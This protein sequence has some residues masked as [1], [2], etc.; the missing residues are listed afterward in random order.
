MNCP[1]DDLVRSPV[2][3]RMSGLRQSISFVSPC[4][5]LKRWRLLRSVLQGVQAAQVPHL[6]TRHVEKQGTA[7]LVAA[8]QHWAAE[9]RQRTGAPTCVPI[10]GGTCCQEG[11]GVGRHAFLTLRLSL[12]WPLA[13]ALVSPWQSSGCTLC[14]RL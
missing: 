14:L 7:A 10:E 6:L 1:S 11:C 13:A 3:H 5:V 2:Q 8:A 9:C 4:R 12:G